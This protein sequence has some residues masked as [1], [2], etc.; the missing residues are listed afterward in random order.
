M[1]TI[2]EGVHYALTTTDGKKVQIIFCH[3]DDSSQFID[4]ITS[5]DLIKVL[6]DRYRVFSNKVDTPENINTF[7]HMRQAL[8]FAQ[9]RK[10]KKLERKA[11]E[12]GHSGNHISVQ[13]KSRTDQHG[14]EPGTT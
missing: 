14:E 3:R 13:V 8:H 7:L 12:N 11:S 4:G 1:D 6:V 9:L 10:K 5:E 2:K